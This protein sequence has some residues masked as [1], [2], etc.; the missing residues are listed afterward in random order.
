MKYLVVLF[1]VFVA[2]SAQAITVHPALMPNEGTGASLLQGATN[3]SIIPMER[4]TTYSEPTL[5][6]SG[7]TVLLAINSTD[8]TNNNVRLFRSTDGGI[9]FDALGTSLRDFPGY[10]ALGYD[11]SADPVLTYAQGRFYFAAVAFANSLSTVNTMTPEDDM[12]EPDAMDC[13]DGEQDPNADTNSLNCEAPNGMVITTSTDGQT[14]TPLK[15]I[16][17]EG[18]YLHDRPALAVDPVSKRLWAAWNGYAGNPCGGSYGEPYAQY[19][20]DKAVT[21]STPKRITLGDYIVYGTVVARAEGLTVPLIGNTGVHIM[22][23]ITSPG[24]TYS[25]AY[26]SSFV[27]SVGSAPSLNDH[28]I[29]PG[30]KRTRL[31]STVTMATSPDRARS[32]MVWME[33]DP[34]GIAHVVASQASTNLDTGGTWSA[35]VRLPSCTGAPVQE[36][37]L[38]NVSWFGGKP[39]EEAF[40]E[41]TPVYDVPYYPVACFYERLGTV[42][43]RSADA[44]LRYMCAQYR[45]AQWTCLTHQAFYSI[46]TAGSMWAHQFLGDYTGMSGELVAFTGIAQRPDNGSSVPYI[47]VDKVRVD[48]CQLGPAA[49]L[50]WWPL[51]FPL[52]V[53]VG[54]LLLP[55]PAV[56]ACVGDCNDDGRVSIADLITSV[57]VSLEVTPVTACEAIDCNSDGEEQV[58]INCLTVVV[59]R[60]LHG[61]DHE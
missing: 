8:A 53:F 20:D 12:C 47:V 21:W 25:Y 54:R 35:P 51:L 26:Q 38:P 15:V 19:S 17:N 4:S 28:T 34:A 61:C 45:N 48:A 1:S 14:W 31:N 57:D 22:R 13:E 43:G 6:S 32:V 46:Q 2:V 50:A 9:S 30:L 16:A 29:L 3:A 27:A 58:W 33:Q 42:A 56:A 60:A 59:S 41:P 10:D 7:L 49:P 37:F 23:L 40:E 52:L 11:Q 36:S 55:T 18:T 39:F 5:V 24:T 44:T